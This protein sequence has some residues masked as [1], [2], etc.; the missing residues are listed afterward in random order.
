[1]INFILKF[2][3]GN[4]FIQGKFN[5][6]GTK[7]NKNVTVTPIEPVEPIDKKGKDD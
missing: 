5:N 2:L 6:L 1:M 4:S 7:D 3:F